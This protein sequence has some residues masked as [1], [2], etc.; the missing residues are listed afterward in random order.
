MCLLQELEEEVSSL[1]EQCGDKD[2]QVTTLMA[3]LKK[4]ADT[5]N[6]AREEA[7][8]LAFQ[9]ATLTHNY[10]QLQLKLVRRWQ[11]IVVGLG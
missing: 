10:D 1:L 9:L 2:A 7:T 5:G 4:A 8:K 11:G 3:S 6:K